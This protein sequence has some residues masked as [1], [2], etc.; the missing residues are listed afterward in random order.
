MNT[1]AASL[2]LRP[3]LYYSYCPGP[4]EKEKPVLFSSQQSEDSIADQVGYDDAGPCGSFK[5]IG[6][7]KTYKE[8]EHGYH[9]RTDN[10]GFKAAADAHGGEGGEDDKAGDEQAP[11]IRMPSTT[12]TAV[13]TASR[14]L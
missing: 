5:E 3:K 14:V 7:D 1:A 9:C 8:T 4:G 6:E 11:I 12:V 13:S 2:K 10:Y